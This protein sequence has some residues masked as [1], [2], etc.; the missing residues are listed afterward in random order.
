MKNERHVSWKVKWGIDE[1][2]QSETVISKLIL[3]KYCGKPLKLDISIKSVKWFQTCQN[4]KLKVIIRY[5]I[6]YPLVFTE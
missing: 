1:N 5:F 4:V 3:E 6:I 2:D